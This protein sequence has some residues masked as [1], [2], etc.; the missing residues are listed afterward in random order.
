MRLASYSV[1]PLLLA[2]AFCTTPTA[3]AHFV[4][5]A[6]E[7]DSGGQPTANVWFSE[8][9]EPDSAELLDRI[10]AVN[11][12]SRTAS[13]PGP[14]ISLTKKIAAGGGAWVG[15]APAGTSALSAFINY[16]VLKRGEQ[17]FLLHY[18]AK[19]L[20]AAAKDLKALA[21][22]DKLAF[23]IVPTLAGN[24]I[25]LEVL[26]RGKPAAEAEVVILDPTAQ[27]ST[28]KTDAAGR[29][30]LD[31]LKAGLYSIRAKWIVK[32]A[33]KAGDQEYPQV[34][35]Y[36]TLALR[37]PQ[38][39]AGTAQ[40]TQPAAATALLNAARQSRVVW[41]NFPGFTANL[42]VF[43]EGRQH[44]GQIKTA[45]DGQITLTGFEL[46]DEKALLGTLRSL[47]THRL[48][49]SEENGAA[50]FADEELNHPLGRL[51]NLVGDTAHSTYRIKDNVIREVNRQMGG[52]RFTISVFE[53]N[54]NPEGKYLPGY[55]TVSYWN[56]DGSLKTV[57]VI[58]ESW[59]RVGQFDLPDHYEAVY[60]GNDDHRNLSL[61]FSNYQL[62]K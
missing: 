31:N 29:L 19:Y 47:I 9:A 4:W 33:G 37:V 16:G 21:R 7:K 35:H 6:V 46:Q 11:V 54:R 42:T 48:S 52:G 26:F 39:L 2:A 17:S 56:A 8:L 10:A 34:N 55:Y 20:D 53:V 44:Q 22:E 41:H 5:L 38:S 12:W 30:A 49:A 28:A 25:S 45:S 18:H 43:A 50:T 58:R 60:T 40:V 27:E 36:S 32:E 15:P 59:Q 51:L 13:G 57:T 1:A 14:Q 61:Q 62:L 23:D 24:K 3:S